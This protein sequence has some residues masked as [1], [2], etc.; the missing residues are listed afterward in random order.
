[1]QIIIAAFIGGFVGAA[2]GDLTGL[3]WIA[4]ILGGIL[5]VVGYLS[6]PYLLA[7]LRTKS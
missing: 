1:M 6:W 5:G 3:G 2:L 4:S 7:V